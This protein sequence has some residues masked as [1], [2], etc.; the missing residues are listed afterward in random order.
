MFGTKNRANSA[1]DIQYHDQQ[2]LAI[3][4]PDCQKQNGRQ[5]QMNPKRRQFA[6]VIACIGLPLCILG[7]LHYRANVPFETVQQFVS[8]IHAKRLDS[9]KAMIVETDRAKLPQEYWERIAKT[10]FTEDVG[11][12]MSYT[13][14]SLLHSLVVFWINVPD[15]ASWRRDPSVQYHAKGRRITVHETNL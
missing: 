10:E 13:T 6:L 8:H 1:D 7:I 3:D 2:R 12:S 15:G 14:T 5:A 11:W 9:A 4:C